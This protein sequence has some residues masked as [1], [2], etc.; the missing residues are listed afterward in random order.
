MNQ[1][2]RAM[3][4]KAQPTL[5]DVHVNGPLT[6]VSVA[7]YQDASAFVFHQAFPNVPVQQRSDKYFVWNKGDFFRLVAGVRAPGDP[8]RSMGMKLTTADFACENYGVHFP[9]ADMIASNQDNPLNLERAA[10]QAVTQ[11]MLILQEVYW[12]STFF[13]NGVWTN[14]STPSPKWDAGSSTP[15]KDIRDQMDARHAATGLRPNTLILGPL[16]WSGLADNADLISRIQYSQKGVVGTDLLKELLGLDRVLIAYGVQ[17]TAA[18]GATDSMSFIAG[19]HA[20][21]CYAAPAPSLLAPSAGYTFSWNGYIGA[22]DNGYRIKRFR[23]E[24]IA[25]WKIEAEAAFD[26]KIVADDCGH[27]FYAAAT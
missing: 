6:N 17:N 15:I 24:D 18:E 4:A 26:Q 9:V 2:L 14:Q 13:A 19:P 8:T 21:L 1:A 5:G 27:F 7:Y 25:S 20:L 16:A 3:L 10:T 12:T 23:N 22:A 11:Q